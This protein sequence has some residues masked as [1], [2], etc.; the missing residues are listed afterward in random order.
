MMSNKLGI[1]LA[2]CMAMAVVGMVGAAVAQAE[3]NKGPLWIVGSP[4][5]G[6][7]AGETRAIRA[8]SEAVPIFKGSLASIE[9][10]KATG[11][12]ILLGG[13]PGT[14][15]GKTIFEECRLKGKSN[16]IAIGL[17]PKA[18]H[19]GEIV[20]NVLTELA[21]PAN[22]SRTSA[23]GIAAPEGEA[24][25]EN[26]LAEFELKNKA[27]ATEG[28]CGAFNEVKIAVKASGST[29]K[30]KNETRNADQIAEGGYAEGGGF[31]LSTPGSTAEVGL[32]R[33][34][35]TAIKE[36]ELYNTETAKYEQ[37]RAE[38][39][40]GALLGQVSSV[41]SAEA[42]TEPKEPFGWGY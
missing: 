13:S 34:P 33:L 11:E 32:L 21:F 23:V 41:G 15:S 20:L 37:I 1:L 29:I 25:N 31:V 14:G 17:N 10:E 24:D 18:A 6:L 28:L 40:A 5:K 22:G 19:S 36:A 3:V 9:C 30:I 42:E 7:K 16:C 27:G 35:E 4:A 2:S 26:L 39:T 8:R 38:M 12:A